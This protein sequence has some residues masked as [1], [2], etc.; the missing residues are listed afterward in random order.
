MAAIVSAFRRGSL[1]LGRFSKLSEVQKAQTE[2]I[3]L[4]Y[5]VS[6][7]VKVP[8]FVQDDSD[9]HTLFLEAFRISSSRNWSSCAPSRSPHSVM[10][11]V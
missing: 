2:A 10:M 9:V 5:E 8:C 4:Y 6:G 3:M 7:Q 1:R 11:S